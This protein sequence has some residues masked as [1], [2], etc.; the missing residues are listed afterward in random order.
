MNLQVASQGAHESTAAS[1]DGKKGRTFKGR[2]ANEKRRTGRQQYID[3]VERN[4]R[5]V[6]LNARLP[7]DRFNPTGHLLN[8]QV[9]R[10]SDW[11]G[12]GDGQAGV[13]CESLHRLG[14]AV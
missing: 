10:H 8:R 13:A 11:L 3:L 12:H 6:G 2:Q 1:Q 5:L 14:C 7:G 4:E 9:G